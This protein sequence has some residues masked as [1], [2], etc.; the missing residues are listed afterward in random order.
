MY[1]D[2]SEIKISMFAKFHLV[3][4]VKFEQT[5]SYIL[6]RSECSSSGPTRASTCC[7]SVDVHAGRYSLLQIVYMQTSW[8]CSCMWSTCIF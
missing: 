5:L 8:A 7:I 2:L 1:F 3:K 6:M 4:Y